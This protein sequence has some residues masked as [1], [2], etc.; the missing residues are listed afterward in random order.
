MS[1]M[2]KLLK[3]KPKPDDLLH[4]ALGDFTVPSFPQNILEGLRALRDPDTNLAKIADQLCAD[5][6][7][8]GQLLRTANAPLHG[9]RR[10]VKNVHHAVSL[11]GRSEV[12]SLLLALA[13]KRSLP[14]Q[15]VVGF[16][17]VRFWLTAFQRAT[18]ARA[19]AHQLHPATAS[20]SFTAALLQD[21]AVPFLAH[22]K[23]A[24]YGELVEQW[25]AGDGELSAL[26]RETFGWDH[27][28]IAEA[29]CQTWAFPQGLRRAI[30]AHHDHDAKAHGVPEAV[31]LVARL[32]ATGESGEIDGLVTATHEAS[33][34]PED[35]VRALVETAFAEAEQLSQ[36]VLGA[37]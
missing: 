31:T 8:S 13:V 3:R 11:L 16:Q 30:A 27:G 5:P 18:T 2:L 21:M 9:L 15:A 14:R 24:S 19:L 35:R 37:R 6:G 29:I 17:P 28:Q 7:I 22:V 4:D 36:S 26:E 32:R 25:R 23:G 33:H 12:E 10:P 34:L 20:E 1:R